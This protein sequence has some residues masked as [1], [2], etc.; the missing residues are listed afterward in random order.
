LDFPFG[1]GTLIIVFFHLISN[2][3]SISNLIQMYFAINRL[4]GRAVVEFTVEKGDGSTFVPTAGGESK[5]VATV[6]VAVCLI[7]MPSTV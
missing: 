7:M 6:Q 5:N 4:T 2:K 3:G 1:L